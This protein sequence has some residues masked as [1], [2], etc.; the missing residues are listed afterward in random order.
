MKNRVCVVT[1]GNTGIGKA[2]VLAL[3]QK[4]MQVVMVSRNREK[5]ETAVQDLL[6]TAPDATIDMVVGDVGTITATRQLAQDLLDRYAHIHILIN[7]AGIWPTK[8][9]LNEDGL[10]QSFMVNYLAPFMLNQLLY[11][12]LKASVPARIVNVSAG[13]YV[14]GKVDLNK[15]P[16]GLDFHPIRTYANTK[17][18]N[19]LTLPLESEWLNGSGITINAVHPGVIR[20][21]LGI[22]PGPVGWFIG[23]V[24][25]SW[26]T[27]EQ[28]PLLL[29]GWPRHRS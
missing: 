24:K 1:G 29:Y 2:I 23:L 8:R 27:P 3:A 6:V 25:R 12:R 15:T 9:I 14:N 16:Y 19:V 11:N 4:Q 13:L 21:N 22:M 26:G 18:C 7:N 5:G 28:G 17:L 10:E 20:T